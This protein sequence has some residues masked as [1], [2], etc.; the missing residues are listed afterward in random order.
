MPQWY[1]NGSSVLFV[2]TLTGT[3]WAL[4]DL[5]VGAKRVS[6]RVS[7][8]TDGL[9]DLLRAS[10]A[11]AEGAHD[12]ALV[13][14]EEPGCNELSLSQRSGIVTIQVWHYKG[15]DPAHRDDLGRLRLH[16]SCSASDLCAAI[17]SGAREVLSELGEAGYREQWDAHYFPTADLTR[18]ERLVAG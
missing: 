14:V 4:V 1:P 10:I 2:Y 8:L 9:G 7:Y 13:W 12:R 6:L 5:A 16:A 15:F 18:L 3:G 17:A 11:I